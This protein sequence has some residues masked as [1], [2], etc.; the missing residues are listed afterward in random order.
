MSFIMMPP[1]MLPMKSAP[2]VPRAARAAA[3]TVAATLAVTAV[4][5]DLDVRVVF[6]VLDEA[7]VGLFAEFGRHDAVDQESLPVAEPNGST[8]PD[9]SPEERGRAGTGCSCRSRPSEGGTA[10][11]Y[12]QGV[13]EALAF[14]CGGPFH[15]RAAGGRVLRRA[16]GTRLV[17]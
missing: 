12:R 2:A 10:E 7:A 4:H 1:W 11:E 13:A 5:D 8:C 9:G 3:R 15:E 16:P 6:V 17:S 14:G